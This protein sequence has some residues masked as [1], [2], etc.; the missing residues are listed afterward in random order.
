MTETM[1]RCLTMLRMLPRAPRKIDTATVERRLCDEGYGVTRRTIQRDLHLLARTMP[2]F[3]DE[4]RPA[5]WCW[6]PEAA[7]IDLPGMDP[8]TALMFTLVERFLAPLL[9]RSTLRVQ[10]RWQCGIDRAHA[11]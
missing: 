8:N 7:L 9:P 3:C 11:P 4:H 10:S 6:A 2:L 5:G 1:L